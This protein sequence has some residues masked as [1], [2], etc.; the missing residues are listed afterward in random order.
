MIRNE[1]DF[2]DVPVIFLT[3]KGDRQSVMNVMELK[4]EGYLL[5]SMEPSKIVAA[6]DSYFAKQE[7]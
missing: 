3:S 4:P 5:K 1:T 7:E 6:V 2:A